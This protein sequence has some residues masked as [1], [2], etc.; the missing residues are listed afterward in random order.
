MK[1][2]PVDMDLFPPFTGFPEEGIKFLQRLKKNNNRPWFQKHKDEY[3]LNVRFPMQCLVAGLA[4]RMAGPA[5]E[6]RF[7]PK[8]SIFRIYRDVRFSK[9]K[10]PYKTSIAAVFPVTGA[11]VPGE[12]PGLYVHVEPGEVFVGGGVYMPSG[13]QLKAFRKS[14]VEHPKEFLSIIHTREFKRMFGG[15]QGDTLRNAP[16]GFPRDHAM[17]EHLRHKQWYV[18]KVLAPSTCL[19]PRFLETVAN[20]FETTMPLVRWLAH[21]LRS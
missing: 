9:N 7:D 21:A 14:L 6:V 11:R 10:E 15:I 1:N 12:N 8:K 19:R 3:E 16:L 20:V 13:D 2:H 17:I 5:P 4:D 18:G